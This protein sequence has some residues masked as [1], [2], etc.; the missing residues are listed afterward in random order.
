MAKQLNQAYHFD[1]KIQH[2]AETG[3]ILPDHLL[4]HPYEEQVTDIQFDEKNV[5]NSPRRFKESSQENQ[6]ADFAFNL[7]V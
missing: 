1:V 6:P 2:S 7:H 3:L 4:H 5:K